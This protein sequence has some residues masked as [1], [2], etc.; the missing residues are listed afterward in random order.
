M[1]RMSL[2]FSRC[3]GAQSGPGSGEDEFRLF[4]GS[5]VEVGDDE[6]IRSFRN[7]CDVEAEPPRAI[8]AVARVVVPKIRQGAMQYALHPLQARMS[9]FC[10]QAVV[11]AQMRK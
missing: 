11:V 4:D 5:G 7:R 9:V 3:G 8:R 2:G 6:A 10:L 1:G